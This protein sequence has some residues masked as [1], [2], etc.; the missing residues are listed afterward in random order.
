M[1]SLALRTLRFRKGG[2][3]AT[4][5]AIFFGAALIMACGGLMESGVR[6]AVPAQRLAAA[7]LVVT[8]DQTYDGSQL[9]E[10]VR[11]DAAQVRAVAAVP[12]VE[13]AIADVSFPV[14][15]V[16]DGRPVT[17]LS[18]NATATEHRPLGHGWDS[19]QLTPYTLA[20]GSQPQ[21]AGDVVLDTALATRAG[22]SVGDRVSVVAAGRTQEFRLSGIV[23]Q[24]GGRTA[25]QPAVF[26]T[27]KRAGELSGRPGTADAVGVLPKPGTDV[28]DLATLVK[29]A[30]KGSA[31]VT[32]TG[33][34]RGLAEFPQA[35]AGQKSLITLSAIFGGWAILVAMFG[36]SSTLGLTVQQRHREMALM[37]AIG[38]TPR[39]LRRMILG[40]TLF[41]AIVASVLGCL[42]GAL[43]SELLFDKLVSAGM[44]S[45]AVEFRL[46]VVPAVV[47]VLAS[48]LAGVGA[49]YITARKIAKTRAT[50]ALA[51]SSMEGRWLTRTRI[52]LSV[53]FLVGG[54]GMAVMTMTMMKGDL[55]ASTAGPACIMWAIGLAL[56]A[57]GFTKII[58]ALLQGPLRA[59][60]GLSGQMAVLNSRAHTIRMAATITPIILLTGIATGTLYMQQIEDASNRSAHTGI[61]RADEVLTSKTGPIAP[62]TLSRVR[63][64][65][66][67]EA[68]SD[69][70]TSTGFMQNPED[71]EQTSDGR[72]LQAVGDIRN[73]S[74][75]AAAGSL[76]DLRGDSV[77]LP[78]DYASTLG[79][80]VG[81][82]VTLRLGDGTQAKVK[83]V[84]T[85]RAEGE[86]TALLLPSS[87]LA[88][89]T[90]DGAASQ[91]LVRH[92]PG[93]DAAQVTAAV[94]AL[95]KDQ[96]GVEVTDSAALVAGR[97]EGQQQLATINYLVVGMIVGYTAISVVNT[98]IAA[99]GRRRRE[100][101][102]QQ[103]TGFTRRQVMAMMSLESVLT[104]VVGVLL[105][106]VAATIT[107]FPYSVAK[108]D[109][110]VPSVPVWIYLAV[111]AGAV[112]ITFAATLLPAWRA[113]K[114]R[115]VEAATAAA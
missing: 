96:P 12:G 77:A 33:D 11:L 58:V 66:G 72:P 76:D 112:A 23:K 24:A 82:S 14:A 29:N 71:A 88:A 40:E 106:T 95:V 79:S 114:L 47:A 39:Q 64:V 97:T 2:F 6:D 26:F 10:R 104:A 87:L 13:K 46:S 42:P 20:S 67:V 113:T 50:E 81:T 36:A 45:G 68:A 101:G 74:V 41:V 89:H 52:I 98:L 100:F 59:L 38:T 78:V 60:G 109:R 92:A 62:G 27:D 54:A 28:A 7:P 35:A 25:S 93:A 55:T 21:S 90:T 48:L 15:V 30:A 73:L 34:N 22:A 83:V 108:L 1:W 32:L 5:I 49:A 63:Q 31:V 8:G 9:A 57:P 105:G 86:T 53:L 80:G 70:V 61:L 75:R 69:Y 91:I 107:L 43:L 51:E 3:V 56:L 4:F 110:V 85:Y 115:P 103:L 94:T 18:D 19:A 84:A 65:P 16:R 99:T 37:K 102:L 111:V 17:D 44:V